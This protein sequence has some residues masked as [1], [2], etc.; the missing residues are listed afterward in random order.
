MT[1]LHAFL[2]KYTKM[3]D[4]FQY[5][6]KKWKKDIKMLE[7]PIYSKHFGCYNQIIKKRRRVL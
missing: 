5:M 6:A 7:I 4:D 1:C 2:N 3:P